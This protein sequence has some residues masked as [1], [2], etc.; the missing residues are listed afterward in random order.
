MLGRLSLSA[1]ER[2]SGRQIAPLELEVPIAEAFHLLEPLDRDPNP[3]AEPFVTWPTE[4]AAR[5]RA[6]RQPFSPKH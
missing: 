6:V 5:S 3:D 4:A 1:S 2:A